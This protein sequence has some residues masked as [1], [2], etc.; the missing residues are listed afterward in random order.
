MHEI[1]IESS[2]VEAIRRGEK[3]IEG[4]LGTPR[5]L[6]MKEGD[7]ISIREDIWKDGNVAESHPDALQLTIRQV[8]YF[9]SF[10]EM[11]EAVDYESVVPTA[12][13]VNEA[14][15]KYAE[16]YSAEDEAAY[17]VVAFFFV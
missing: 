11:L 8:L 2:L 5:F 1:G 3:T 14:V 13:S 6:A 12:A 15:A 4:H 16:F 17:G 7:M 9:E 10:R